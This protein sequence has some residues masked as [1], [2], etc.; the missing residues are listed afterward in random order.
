MPLPYNRCFSGKGTEHL[1]A[2][3]HVSPNVLYSDSEINFYAM[4]EIYQHLNYLL[5]NLMCNL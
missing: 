5:G 1:K 3:A 2:I 4:P